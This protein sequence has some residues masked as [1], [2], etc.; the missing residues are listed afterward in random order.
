MSG[1]ARLGADLG[2]N[3]KTRKAE[4]GLPGKLDYHIA[5]CSSWIEL[6]AFANLVSR[7][8]WRG[9][10]LDLSVFRGIGKWF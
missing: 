8:Q 3:K 6:Y 2:E 10:R 7:N 5:Q 4:G 9:T 1:L